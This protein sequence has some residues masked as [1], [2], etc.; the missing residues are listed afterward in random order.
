MIIL[1]KPRGGHFTEV[2]HFRDQ[3]SKNLCRNTAT[4]FLLLPILLWDPRVRAIPHVH[5][6]LGLATSPFFFWQQIRHFD[7]RSRSPRFESL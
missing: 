3:N 7:V 2:R 1:E 6:Q 5:G 4:S